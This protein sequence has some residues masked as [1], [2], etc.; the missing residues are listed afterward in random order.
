MRPPGARTIGWRVAVAVASIV[1]L[2]F[3]ATL[4]AS[5]DDP[6]TSSFTR[7]GVPIVQS[8]VVN[9]RVFASVG[10]W[11][12]NPTSYS[13]QWYLNDVAID[14]ATNSTYTPSSDEQDDE[15]SV[16]VTVGLADY[17]TTTAQSA[18]TPILGQLSF[19]PASLSGTYATGQTVTVNPGTWSQPGV[20]FSYQ[21]RDEYTDTII[22]SGPDASSIVLT[23]AEARGVYVGLTG[24]LPGYGSE[25]TP[26]L[27]VP[28]FAPDE[29]L[30]GRVDTGGTAEHH[31]FLTAGP[32][33][34]T[35]YPNNLTSISYQWNRNGQ[36]IAGATNA[37][38]LVAAADV[39][40]HITVT[41]TAASGD[42]TP[43]SATSGIMTPV[44]DPNAFP[45]PTITGTP[46]IGRPLIANTATGSPDLSNGYTF[47]WYV[48]GVRVEDASGPNFYPDSESQVG[49]TV[50]VVTEGFTPAGTILSDPSKPTVPIAN[51]TIHPVVVQLGYLGVGVPIEPYVTGA[52]NVNWLH[53]VIYRD[54]VA[55][56]NNI[57]Y[58]LT[59]ADWRHHITVAETESVPGWPPVT[60]T[61]KST[62]VGEGNFWGQATYSSA[63]T[64][65][66]RTSLDVSSYQP[67]PAN[68]AVEWRLG[69]NVLTSDPII[70][71]GTS[72][73]I[74][75]RYVGHYIY[76]MYTLTGKDM[77]A[78]EAWT[79]P[80]KVKPGTLP[81]PGTPVVTGAGLV[82][83]KLVASHG[84]LPAS[85]GIT[86]HYQWFSSVS[87]TAT[88]VAIV[89]ATSNTFVPPLSLRADLISVR[90]ISTKTGYT[91]VSN[92]SA[93]TAPLLVPPPLRPKP[94]EPAIHVIS[95]FAHVIL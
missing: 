82:G 17:T 34:N 52:I 5:A 46:E 35:W 12:P 84:T 14:G 8:P 43:V 58:T 49:G 41:V 92:F 7:V 91:E 16:A 63:P 13:Y 60:T 77:Y 25:R 76:A 20:T 33:Y 74:P 71:R 31:H 48:N 83:T 36:P 24:S 21:W 86:Y 94:T 29:Q 89:H 39:G 79:D 30:P 10:S 11:A 67:T 66:V 22:A 3:G 27:F 9:E 56:S 42:F 88:P 45:I 62:L 37:N 59:A 93:L 80:I 18:D 70:G 54:G 95:P 53:Y 90:V 23:S 87:P 47:E 40:Q 81:A 4:S 57:P 73:T 44:E 75:A 51:G 64:V 6:G 61:T 38:Y 78:Y 68:V 85:A 15:L 2:F 32:D 19:T 65:G 1:A 69:T 55:I 26:L 50:T 28:A 72:F